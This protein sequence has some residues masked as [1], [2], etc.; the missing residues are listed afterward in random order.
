MKT[1]LRK[2]VSK[3]FVMESSRT[4]SLLSPVMLLSFVILL[5]CLFP[6]RLS[7][8]E[9]IPANNEAKPYTRWWWLGSA[10]D[11]AG[12]KYNLSEYAKVGIGGVEI[13]PIYGVQGND[14]NDISYLSPRWMRMLK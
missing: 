11:S 14:A 13:T 8:Q 5:L 9:W 2:Y 10:V 1:T 7:A 4:I 6:S 12:I 3:S